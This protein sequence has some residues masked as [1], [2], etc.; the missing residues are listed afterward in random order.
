MIIHQE[1]CVVVMQHRKTGE[2][3]E[4]RPTNN[5]AAEFMQRGHIEAQERGHLSN[6]WDIFIEDIV[7]D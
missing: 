7:Y 2:R 6:E 5:N 4:S 1:T 3:I